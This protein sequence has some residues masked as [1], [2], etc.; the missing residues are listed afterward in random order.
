MARADGERFCS[1]S[2]FES[3]RNTV[4]ISRF[5]NCGV[6]AKEPSAAAGGF[7]TVAEKR[8]TKDPYM[9]WQPVRSHQGIISLGPDRTKLYESELHAAV[10]IACHYGK[11]YS[12]LRTLVRL[13]GSILSYRKNIV[14]R[15]V[16][17]TNTFCF[18]W[19]N[20]SSAF[21]CL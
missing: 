18:S 16:S 17:N 9:T 6:G 7:S 1:K 12:I 14:K 19:Q 4:C 15:T 21:L 5:S 2:K 3:R 11:R 10:S 8:K 13:F 20:G